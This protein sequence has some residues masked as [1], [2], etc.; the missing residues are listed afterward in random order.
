MGIITVKLRDDVEK[1]LR[2]LAYSKYGGAKG[3]LS[4]VIEEGILKLAGKKRVSSRR[5][6]VLK[7]GKVIFEAKDLDEVKK[8]LDHEKLSLRDVTIISV[9]VK[10]EYRIGP[11][12][13]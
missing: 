5:F 2:E 11:R 13:G 8:F 4:R 1:L 12:L 9:P 6:R 10:V 3:S 7:D